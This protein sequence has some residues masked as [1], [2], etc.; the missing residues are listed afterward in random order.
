MELIRERAQERVMKVGDLVTYGD[1]YLHN[2]NG[3]RRIGVIIDAAT[4]DTWFVMW[5][6][7]EHEWECGE[8]LEV[9]D[10]RR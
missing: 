6:K 2:V 10:E 9:V 3:E 1:W 5:S 4:Q 7:H 8:D